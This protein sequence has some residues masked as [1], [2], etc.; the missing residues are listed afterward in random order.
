MALPTVPLPRIRPTM[1]AQGQNPLDALAAHLQANPGLYWTL[2]AG[3]MGGKQALPQALSNMP[4]AMQLDSGRQLQARQ[5]KAVEGF[6][7]SQALPPA[8][9]DLYRAFPDQAAQ[10]AFGGTGTTSDIKNFEFARQN[11]FRG[12]F[13]DWLAQGAGNNA[14]RRALQPTWMQDSSGNWV[15][16]Q[17]TQSGGLE[18]SQLPE[19]YKAVPPSDVIGAKQTATVDA[20]TA[21]AARAALPAAEQAATIAKQAVDALRNDAAGQADQFGR[22]LGV[23]PQQWTPAIPGTSKANFRV[24]L[25]QA[26]GQAFMQARAMLKG[27]GQITDYEGRRGEAA[28][29]R[30]TAAAEQGSRD[31]FL[32]ALDDFEQAV[33]AGY[34]KLQAAAQGGYTEGAVKGRGGTPPTSGW[35]IEEVQ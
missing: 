19:G 16:G 33:E 34:E 10:Q 32:R 22:F 9:A 2:A 17:L 4:A 11:G 5:Q 27:G 3:L 14:N 29:S 7:Q 31:E 12:T 6:I 30:M 13:Q 26:T 20:K 15:P 1:Q 23:V 24:K 35:S 21:G 28:Y 25:E 8:T 18:P